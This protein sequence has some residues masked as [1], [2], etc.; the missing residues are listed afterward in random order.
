MRLY[1]LVEGLTEEQFATR[2]L[3]PHL[4]PRGISTYP[5]IVETS[6]DRHGRKRRGGGDWRM[7]RRDLVKLTGQQ[8]GSDVRITT[9]FDLYGLPNQFPGI[10]QHGAV[11]DTRRRAE[12]LE[13]ALFADIGDWRLIPYLQ[14]HEFEALVL[15]GLDALKEILDAAEHRGVSALQ[16]IVASV[17]PEDVDDGPD[18]APSKRLEASIPSYEKAVHGPLAVETTGL[19]RLR[20]TCPRF[21]GWVAKLEKLGEGGGAS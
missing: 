13:E 4:E 20:A 18:T 16:E 10:A 7:W 2:L 19:A 12:L 5:I 14:R 9:M 17:P 3:K 6:R 1:I 15:A 11:G 21:A 8:R